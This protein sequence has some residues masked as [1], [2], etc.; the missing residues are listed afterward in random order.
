MSDTD[1][2]LNFVPTG[3]VPT[4]ADNPHLPVTI[5]EILAEVEAAINVGITMVHVHVR[6]AAQ[7]PTLD[8]NLY[9]ELI[10]GIRHIDPE[11]VVCLSCSGR[12]SPDLASR[13][14]PLMLKGDAKP[15]LA[16]LTL[17][18]LNFP[19]QAS[20]TAPETVVGLAGEMLRLGIVP[21][22]EI[23]DLGM[24]NLLK[25]LRDRG[26]VQDPCYVNFLVGNLATAQ[27]E[28]GV[29]SLFLHA[30]P[31]D[32]VWSLGGIGSFQLTANTLGLALGGGVRV[33]LEDNLFFDAQRSQPATNLQ[34]IHRVHGLA[35]LLDRKVMSPRD[36]R[37]KMRLLPG[38]GD[39]GRLPGP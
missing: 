15:D 37:K 33:G 20:I 14:I 18:S 16:S 17:G 31:S 25:Y 13:R 8:A 38:N 34:L 5:G 2:V 24:T 1:F 27:C 3:M 35:K 7:Q 29:I 4:K 11:L 23:F 36:F 22:L 32:A 6:D 28:P 10:T 12:K 39:Y 21:E 26:I 9:A 19:R 30:L